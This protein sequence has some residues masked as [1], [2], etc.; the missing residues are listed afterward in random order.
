MMILDAARF[1]VSR[2]SAATALAAFFWASFSARFW[3]STDNVLRFAE[4][5]SSEYSREWRSGCL[6][7]SHSSHFLV[8]PPYS[9][10]YTYASARSAGRF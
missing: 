2:A 10:Y 3:A 7:S 8:V 4:S 5:A 6:L 9:Q 1:S